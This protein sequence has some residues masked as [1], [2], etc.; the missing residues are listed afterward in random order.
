[1][2]II[3]MN[4]N[5]K[6]ASATFLPYAAYKRAEALALDMG[7]QIGKTDKGFFKADFSSAKIAKDFVTKW[8]AEYAAAHDAY[9]PKSAPVSEPAPAPAKETK[10]TKPANGKGTVKVSKAVKDALAPYAGKGKSANKE[11][12]SVLRGMNIVP[13]GAE[14]DYWASIR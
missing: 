6:T 7:G 9:V 14:W 13:N 4:Q 12:A 1:M 5:K 8:T 3:A 10:P 11:V 2:S